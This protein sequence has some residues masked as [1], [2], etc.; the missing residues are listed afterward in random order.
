MIIAIVISPAI[1][2]FFMVSG[3]GKDLDIFYINI[4][5]NVL[6]VL[7]AAVLIKKKRC[8]KKSKSMHIDIFTSH[9]S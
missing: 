4:I 2:L 1:V 6:S 7:V 9:K 3:V 5:I 8:I